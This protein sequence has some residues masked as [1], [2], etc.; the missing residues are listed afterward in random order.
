MKDHDRI[1]V[2]FLLNSLCFGG[3]EKHTVTLVNTIDV[4]RYEL[5]LCYLEPEEQLLSQVS[6][7]RLA[8][9]F[10]LDRKHRL[11]WRCATLLSKYV[12]EHDINF[13]V[14][15]NQY[16]MIYGYLARVLSRQDCRLIEILHSTKTKNMYERLK[17]P[18]Y[19]L[20]LNEFD[21]VVFVS[22]N[23]RQYWLG[24]ANLKTQKTTVIR[25]GIDP[26]TY[27]PSLTTEARNRLRRDLG[28]S[29]DDY[30]VGMCSALRPEKRHVDLLDAMTIVRGKGI[31]ARVLIIGD[32]PER[33]KLEQRT[34]EKELTNI[35]KITGFQQDVRPYVEIC[36][37][38]VMAST[39]ETFPIAVL[40]AMALGKPVIS[41]R[42]S[43]AL[44]QI[45]H[46][47]TGLLFA[48]RDVAGFADH[49]ITLADKAVRDEMGQAALRKFLREFTQVQMVERY[50]R[51]FDGLAPSESPRS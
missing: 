15:I 25:N 12:K 37:C 2:L 30:V 45:E 32:G 23:Q 46:G 26:E 48:H 39:T 40:E 22:K 17:R 13:I 50:A 42:T 14:C 43:G 20:L 33:L 4:S 1:R 8:H 51:L 31:S 27:H 49:I 38:L 3:A 19:V 47:K 5:H 16:P 6:I 44:E 21:H 41:S 35:V 7:D 28:F 29:P 18:L 10:C 11:D 36:D 24:K 9:H 34:E